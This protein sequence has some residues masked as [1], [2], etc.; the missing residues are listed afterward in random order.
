[1][2]AAPQGMSTSFEIKHEYDA[3]QLYS[4]E[5]S[6]HAVIDQ[7]E[8]ELGSVNEVSVVACAGDA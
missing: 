6:S 1:M 7:G 2:R 4:L 5:S 8:P 3:A